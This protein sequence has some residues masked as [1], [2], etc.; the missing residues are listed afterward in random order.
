MIVSQSAAKEIQRLQTMKC[1]YFIQSLIQ[2]W[3]P[4]KMNVTSEASFFRR[5][6][7]VGRLKM[8]EQQ[9]IRNTYFVNTVIRAQYPHMH[10]WIISELLEQCLGL[11]TLVSPLLQ[12][13]VCLPFVQ[14]SQ[15]VSPHDARCQLWIKEWRRREILQSTSNF[16]LR[17]RWTWSVLFSAQMDLS[18]CR[19]T[20]TLSLLVLC[21]L[22]DG[23]GLFVGHKSCRC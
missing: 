22:H 8:V 10:H 15:S 3:K 9:L 13:I 5:K 21:H 17:C 4:T 14:G 16:P 12:R 6:L 19:T 23:G 11:K 20:L 2:E 1:F 18:A 7:N